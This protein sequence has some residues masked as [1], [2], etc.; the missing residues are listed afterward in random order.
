MEKVYNIRA[1]ALLDIKNLSLQIN[2]NKL[3]DDLNLSFHEGIVYAIVGRNGVGKTTLGHT[4]M[5]LEGYRNFEGDIFYKGKS[6]KK[7]SI[8]ERARK[9]IT[10]AWQEPARFE[11]I[12]IEKYIAAS[13]KGASAEK[14]SKILKD[15]GM[16]PEVYSCRNVDKNLSGGERKKVELA[17]ILAMKPQLV[18][19]D[20]LDSGI[21]I[22]SLDNIF[23]AIYYLKSNG[24]GVVLITHSLTVLKKAEYAY[25]MCSGKILKHG[26]TSEISKYF[27]KRCLPC[28]H[29]NE[30]EESEIVNEPG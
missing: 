2:G 15:V 11:G 22:D 30:P 24:A 20:E 21:D 19:L 18:I 23:D 10:L 4:I 25:L 8:F 17:S 29:K 12:S 28:K 13:S 7:L 27:S 3:L 9:G 16:N 26:N 5:G 14:V 6:I 1:M